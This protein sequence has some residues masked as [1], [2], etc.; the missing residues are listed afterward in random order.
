MEVPG[1]T[2]GADGDPVHPAVFDVV[3]DLEAERV[4][5]EGQGCVRIVVREV[6]RVNDDVHDG[7]VSCGSVT[8]L[9]DS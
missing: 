9:L 5:I 3:A 6:G 8:A 7:H 4:A 2:G 1:W